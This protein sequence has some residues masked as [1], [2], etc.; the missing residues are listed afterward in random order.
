MN[1]MRNIFTRKP[2]LVAYINVGNT[3]P[4]EQPRYLNDIKRQLITD[5][6]F[7]WFFIPVID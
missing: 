6:E 3:S 2:L 1:W 7:T 5:N 4:S